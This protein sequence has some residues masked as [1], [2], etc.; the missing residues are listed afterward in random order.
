[1]LPQ[2][3]EQSL[4][5]FFLSWTS[6]FRLTP[7]PP[8]GGSEAWKGLPQRP[9]LADTFLPTSSVYISKKDRLATLS[10][11]ARGGRKSLGRKGEGEKD[12]RR[13]GLKGA[14]R[15]GGSAAD[16]KAFFLFV[17]LF[18]LLSQICVT[19]GKC[20]RGSRGFTVDLV[21]REKTIIAPPS[22]PD[23]FLL[24]SLFWR[25]PLVF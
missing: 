16:K 3:F 6:V 17:L 21:A 12:L 7:S 4:F 20:E 19:K 10:P 13:E 18:L 5:L 14:R 22:S 2:V 8:S 24:G 1:M 25:I 15:G 23:L 9:C 11:S